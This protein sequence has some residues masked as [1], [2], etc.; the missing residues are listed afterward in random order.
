MAPPRSVVDLANAADR[1]AAVRIGRAWVEM[2]RGASATALRDYLFG[3]DADALDA[4]QMDTLDVLAQRSSWRMSE[5]AE[6]LHVDPS[7]ATRAVQ[8]LVKV[9]LASRAADSDDGRV[10]IVCATNAGRQLH[11]SIDRRRAY[12]ISRLMNAF[13]SQE[14]T[15]LADLLTRFIHELKEVVNDLPTE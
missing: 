11:K 4:G 2:R 3:T 14:R 9:E 12:V 13:T 6:A 8:R 15:R 1:D 10:V 5:L 7:T